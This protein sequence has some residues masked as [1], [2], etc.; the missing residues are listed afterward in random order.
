MTSPFPQPTFNCGSGV[1]KTQELGR[2]K[3]MK[4]TLSTHAFFWTPLSPLM[5]FYKTNIRASENEWSETLAWHCWIPTTFYLNTALTT[6]CKMLKL[7]SPLSVSLMFSS[8]SCAL[9]FWDEL[10][11]FGD[12]WKAVMW[13]YGKMIDCR[14]TQMSVKVCAIKVLRCFFDQISNHV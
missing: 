13:L 3:M 9:E 11:Q 10:E 12:H 8:G 2:L 1:K 6:C 14:W 7:S 5:Y 4:P